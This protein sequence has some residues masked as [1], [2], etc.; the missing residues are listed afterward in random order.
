MYE[1]GEGVEQDYTK[2]LEWYNKAAN[3]GNNVTMSNIGRMYECGKGV[4]QDYTKALEWYTRSYNSGY[5]DASKGVERM[6]ELLQV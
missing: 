1:F 4:E 2:A 6:K 5:K 3:A